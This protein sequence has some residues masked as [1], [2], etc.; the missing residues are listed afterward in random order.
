MTLVTQELESLMHCCGES[1]EARDTPTRQTLTLSVIHGG[2]EIQPSM[3]TPD[4]IART[5]PAK[6]V[7]VEMSALKD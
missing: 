3:N 1:S 7:C 6:L 4:I 2:R 5:K